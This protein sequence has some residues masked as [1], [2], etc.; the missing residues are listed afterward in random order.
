MGDGY[1]MKNARENNSEW[2]DCSSAGPLFTGGVEIVSR[3]ALHF[4]PYTCALQ[5]HLDLPS[6]TT[7]TL[8]ILNNNLPD[9]DLTCQ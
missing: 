9:T 2:N 6:L 7:Q 3:G 4:M 8:E 1:R 5:R